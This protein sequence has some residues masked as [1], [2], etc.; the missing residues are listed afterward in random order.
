MSGL[1]SPATLY[2]AYASLSSTFMLLRT[3][4]RQVVPRR[5]EQF[6]ISVL[7]SFFKDRLPA[8]F[9]DDSM[10][11]L[12]VEMSD[13]PGPYQNNLY[14]SFHIYMSSKATTTTNRLK[15]TTISNKSNKLT[16]KLAQP[17]TLTELYQGVTITLAYLCKNSKDDGDDGYKAK[18][19]WFELRFEKIHKDLVMNSYIPFVLKEANTVELENKDLKLYTYQNTWSPVN[20]EHSST[21]ETLAMEPSEKKDLMDD[22]DLFLKRREF[23]KR[24]GRAWKRG[25]LLYGPPGTGKSSLVA[26]MANYLKFNIYDL[27]LMNVNSD[28]VLR[29]LFMGIANRSILVIED[30]DCSVDLPGRKTRPK[31]A[32]SSSNKDY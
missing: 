29:N 2:A 5:V 19:S 15:I 8:I 28:H 7:S 3:T 9:R 30:I 1:P 24:V 11:T 26:A 18:V 22:L 27:Q 23:F 6:V 25:Y 21:F 10:F 17:E 12:V 4:Y 13:G 20:L 32:R 16:T 14:K 31:N